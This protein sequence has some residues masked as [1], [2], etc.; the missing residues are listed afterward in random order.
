MNYSRVFMAWRTSWAGLTKHENTPPG[1]KIVKNSCW[2]NWNSYTSIW[3]VSYRFSFKAVPHAHPTNMASYRISTLD[4]GAVLPEPLPCTSK[5]KSNATSTSVTKNP[6]SST[7]SVTKGVKGLP[8]RC[9]N[10]TPGA[11][12]TVCRVDET[13]NKK[14]FRCHC[15][16]SITT[17]GGRTQNVL[18]HWSSGKWFFTNITVEVKS[19][20]FFTI[21][22]NNFSLY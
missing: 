12:C 3:L 2:Q 15:G 8:S 13:T 9:P 4:H 11:P 14:L 16:E 22:C 6:A 19:D 18:V 5:E 21:I 17:P 1:I 20:F 7:S 10:A